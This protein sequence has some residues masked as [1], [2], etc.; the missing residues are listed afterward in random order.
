M[1]QS[2]P[3]DQATL[4][5]YPLSRSARVR[6]LL[7]ELDIPH[8]VRRVDVVRGEGLSPAFMAIN[9]NH[10][11]PVLQLRYSDGSEQT[12]LE[13][14]AMI[15]HLADLHPHAELIPPIS[16]PVARG[17]VLQMV[18]FNASHLDTILW[19]IRLHRDLFPKAVRSEATVQFNM[20][21]LEREVLPQLE[22]RLSR[23]DWICGNTFTA[24]DCIMAQNLG[25]MRSYGIGRK[26]ALR[27]YAKR[28][29]ARPSWQE[30]YSDMREFE[31]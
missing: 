1:T 20:D 10:A 16:D 24:A 6:M 13:S 17:D 22:A 9:P 18:A 15:I 2:S 5:H 3:I 12:L 14:G 7:I 23:H 21:K 8:E 27:A 25:W 4:Y 19:N 30:A 28:L 29:Q 26:G 11:V 31:R